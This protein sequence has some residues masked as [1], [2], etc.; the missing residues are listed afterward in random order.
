[1]EF[2]IN[3]HNPSLR[4]WGIGFPHTEES[5]KS[6]SESKKG[7]KQTPEHI[8]KRVNKMTGFKQSQY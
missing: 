8:Q 2:N 3:D 4:R 5:K 1:M 6:I 7:I